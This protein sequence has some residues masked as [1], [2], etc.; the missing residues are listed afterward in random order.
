MAT[1]SILQGTSDQPPMCFWV[2]DATLVVY[3][4]MFTDA[5]PGMEVAIRGN[6]LWP[7]ACATCAATCDGPDSLCASPQA[8]LVDADYPCDRRDTRERELCNTPSALVQAP[9]EI[10]SRPGTLL[11]LDAS[12]S[13]GGGIK[14]L[15]FHWFAHPTKCD[16][17]YRIQPSFDFASTETVTLG[18][19]VDGG[20][21]FRFLLRV[22]T[23]LGTLSEL[24]EIEVHRAQMPIPTIVQA[25]PLLRFPANR[26]LTSRPER[27]WQ[28]ALQVASHR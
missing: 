5:A 28:L 11:T 14:P 16:N 9:S 13:S 6:V 3:L 12:R 22:S 4:T 25:A 20:A 23:F 7:A 17:Y 21:T 19:E 26:R 15:T 27:R 24:Y 10:S 8:V 1:V 2:D 18:S